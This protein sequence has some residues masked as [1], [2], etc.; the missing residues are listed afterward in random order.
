MADEST[1][2]TADENEETTETGETTVEEVAAQGKDPA[3]VAAAL[4]SERASA[5]EARKKA[6]AAEAKVKKFEDRDKS[7]QEKAEQRAVEAEQKAKEAEFK[8]VRLQ[9]AAEKKLPADLA[10][11][12]QGETK[13]ELEADADALLKLVKTENATTLDQGARSSTSPGDDMNARIRAAAGR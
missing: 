8:L 3:A 5:R 11:R 4:R 10:L 2:A 9:V 6:E 1:T 13:E 12:L 7:E